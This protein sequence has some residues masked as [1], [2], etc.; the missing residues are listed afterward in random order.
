MPVKK[1]ARRRVCDN[2]RTIGSDREPL[3]LP[4]K[5]R[6]IDLIGFRLALSNSDDPRRGGT[7]P[8]D[9]ERETRDLEARG[10]QRVEVHEVV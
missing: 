1:P 2:R 3:G 5:T 10:R 9:F 7:R 8:F 4:L 6:R